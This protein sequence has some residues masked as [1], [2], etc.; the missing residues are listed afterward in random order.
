V[1]RQPLQRGLKYGITAT[2][3][4]FEPA[5]FQQF[6]ISLRNEL[7]DLKRWQLALITF[8]VLA[9][10]RLYITWVNHVCFSRPPRHL[11]RNQQRRQ[12]ALPAVGV[13][14]GPFNALRGAVHY[15]TYANHTLRE[16][17]QKHSPTGTW[18]KVSTIS[19]WQVVATSPRIISE[20]SDLPEHILSLSEAEADKIQSSYTSSPLIFGNPYHIK[21]VSTQ[22]TRRLGVVMHDVLDELILAWENDTDIASEWT[23]INTWDVVSTAILQTTNRMFVGLP[24]CRNK[25]YHKAIIDFTLRLFIAG[26]YVD[27]SPRILK[28]LVQRIV[29]PKQRTAKTVMNFMQPIFEERLEKLRKLGDKWTDRPVSLSVYIL[30][31]RE[32]GRR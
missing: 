22:I 18:F 26:V 30:S 20:I 31:E 9:A 17:L 29:L 15:V 25:T 19:G 2:K 3:L 4:K 1:F 28:G 27:I 12:I 32:L 6:T 13:P 11:Q 14:S 7:A 8:G 23:E 21:I 5:N 16:G 24:L 10:W